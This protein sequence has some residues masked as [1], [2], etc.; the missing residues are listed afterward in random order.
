M[1]KYACELRNQV[2]FKR[3]SK[4]ESCSCSLVR[5]NPAK[6][7]ST[8]V[9][10]RYEQVSFWELHGNCLSFGKYTEMAHFCQIILNF[11][12]VVLYYNK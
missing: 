1:C 9:T 11:L 2:K 5:K 4:A 7:K 3:L 10:I 12:S 6:T 8:E